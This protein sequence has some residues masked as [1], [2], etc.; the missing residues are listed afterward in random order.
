MCSRTNCPHCGRPTY[1][2]CGRHIEQVLAD[3]PEAARC[4]CREEAA[5]SSRK[6]SFF[7]RVLS[8]GKGGAR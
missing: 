1:V 6:A 4:H 5:P 2:G 3:V 7:E 8:G